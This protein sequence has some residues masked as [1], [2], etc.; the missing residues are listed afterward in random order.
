M[1]NTP[2]QGE[3]ADEVHL[4]RED[5]TWIAKD[6]A[7]DVASQGRTREEALELLD[8]AVALHRDE[9]GRPVRTG[10]RT[11]SGIDAEAAPAEPRP[12]DAPWLGGES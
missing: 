2:R 7:T 3:R 5:E 9:I 8:E 1:P 10:D 12:P 6:L 4:W 11:E